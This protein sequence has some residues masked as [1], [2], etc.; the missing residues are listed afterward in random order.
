MNFQH[1]GAAPHCSHEVTKFPELLFPRA[2]DR[3]WQ[4]PQ[5]VSEVSGIK[6]TGLLCMGM[7]QRKLQRATRAVH[8]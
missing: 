6:P 8:N 7:D 4:S 1:D 2:M 3:T 5:L